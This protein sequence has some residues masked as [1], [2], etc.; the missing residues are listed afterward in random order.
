MPKLPIRQPFPIDKAGSKVS[1]DFWAV[2][3]QVILGGDDTGY[4]V[5]IDFSRHDTQKDL[6]EFIRSS[7]KF[8]N[9]H[10]PI[11]LKV[12]V[13][14][15]KNS[16]EIPIAIRD[17]SSAQAAQGNPQYRLPTQEKIE[18]SLAYL[19]PK[20]WDNDSIL[21]V[22]AGF[23]LP[24]YGHY[25]VEVESVQNRPIFKDVDSMLI[26]DKYPYIGK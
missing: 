24:E 16:I 19:H 10:E 26:I 12:K 5:A 14:L 13:F 22:V 23:R 3:G 25:R 1:I 6:I 9:D 20:S 8:I 7:E 4:M 21:A 17:Y 15:V 18:Q 2:P 11:A